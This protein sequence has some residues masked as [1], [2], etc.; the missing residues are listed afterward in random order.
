MSRIAYVNGRYLH[1][2]DAAVHV[3]D[4]GYQFADGVYEVI[5]VQRGV[6]IDEAAHLDRLAQSLDALAIAPPMARRVLRLVLRQVIRRNRLGD[7][8]IYIQT[9]RGAARRDHVFP[10][11]NRSAVVITARPIAGQAPELAASG[12]DVIS[13]PDL[14]WDRCDIKSVAL[15]PNVLGKEQ[16]KRADA[17]EAWQV[18][19][20][21][22]VTEGTASNAWIVDDGG[23]VITHPTGAA[24]LNGV[25][26]RSI[27]EIAREL[28]IAAVERP[29]TVD[30]A[31]SATEA[32][33]TSTTSLLLPV[34]RIDGQPV[35]DGRPGPVSLRLRE[36]YI[37]YIADQALR[38]DSMIPV[39]P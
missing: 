31:K 12:V 21:G 13:I 32:F 11:G 26:R 6:L 2:G 10:Q 30:E 17:F 36:A 23:T 28:R 3:E 27:L 29:F 7:G 9:T 22:V 14:R 37:G 35:G 20:G 38:P 34:T 5:S 1:H 8:I 33:L 24:I 19:E 16:A 25:T 15:L 18:T 39:S 4:R